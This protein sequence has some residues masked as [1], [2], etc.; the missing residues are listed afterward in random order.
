MHRKYEI[1]I[2][3][4]CS[5]LQKLQGALLEQVLINTVQDEFNVVYL[6]TDKGVYCLQGEVGGEYLGIHSKKEMPEITSQVGYVICKYTQFIKFEGH[7]IAQVR[8]LGDVWNGHGF[9]I[10]FRDMHTTSMLIQ[11]IYCGSSPEGL[12]DCL[13]LGVG[14]YQNTKT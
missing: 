6:K 14:Q 11:S 8:Q 9:E 12:E 10:N 7:E 5:L 1:E 13:R 4:A 2:N 3:E